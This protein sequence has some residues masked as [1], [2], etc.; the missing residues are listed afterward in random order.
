MKRCVLDVADFLKWAMSSNSL[1]ET[2]RWDINSRFRLAFTPVTR[3]RGSQLDK[4]QLH[5]T[6]VSAL[7]KRSHNTF[8]IDCWAFFFP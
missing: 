6:P 8:S 4:M 7:T 3:A 2:V 5:K 1:N